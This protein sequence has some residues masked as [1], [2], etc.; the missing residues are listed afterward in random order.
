MGTPILSVTASLYKEN[1]NDIN[2]I[3]QIINNLAQDGEPDANGVYTFTGTFTATHN[4]SFGLDENSFK[5]KVVARDLANNET[6]LVSEDISEAEKDNFSMKIRVKESMKPEVSAEQGSW[7]S[8]YSEDKVFIAKFIASDINYTDETTGKFYRFAG[9]DRKKLSIYVNDTLT[10]SPDQ[11]SHQ[12][13]ETYTEPTSSTSNDGVYRINYPLP[14][15][16]DGTY[17]IGII[18]YDNDGNASEKLEKSITI[19]RTAPGV[20]LIT[21]GT[22]PNNTGNFVVSGTVDSSSTVYIE[23]YRDSNLVST[24]TVAVTGENGGSFSKE[25]F[26]QPDGLYKVKVYAKDS[27]GNETKE[28]AEVEFIIDAT[29]PIFKTVKFYPVINGSVSSTPTTELVG[30]LEY[31]IVVTVE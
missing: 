6:T 8:P 28:P 20:N 11:D 18:V 22:E 19:D 1:T 12:Y 5:L 26:G 24:E 9:I 16:E 21:P 15:N 4:S 30:G 13:F 17:K 2:D 27:V 23:I 29:A 31:K 3:M 14:F 25:Y 10:V 7:P